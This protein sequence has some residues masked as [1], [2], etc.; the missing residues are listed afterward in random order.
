MQTIN[1]KEKEINKNE[2]KNKKAIQKPKEKVK[3]N[4]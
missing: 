4:N 3:K 1:T 2:F